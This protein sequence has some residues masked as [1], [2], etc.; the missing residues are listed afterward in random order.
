[1]QGFQVIVV[2]DG[3]T[4][5]TLS[6][7]NDWKQEQEKGA[8]KLNFSLEILWQKNQKQGE[9]RN[10]GLKSASG[11][12]IM[13]IGDD[14]F[15]EP[16]CLETHLNMHKQLNKDGDTAILG[17]TDWDRNKMKVS[18]FLDFINNFGAGWI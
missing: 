18:P 3:S 8:T 11:K 16:N 12:I 13:F 7:L 4:D 1:M 15:L 2:D 17:F 5:G 6:F 14:I 9:A 10:Y